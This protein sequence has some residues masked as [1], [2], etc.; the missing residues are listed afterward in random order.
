ML[1]ARRQVAVATAQALAPTAQALVATAQ[2]VV[3]SA[4]ALVASVQLPTACSVDRAVLANNLSVFSH[5]LS[6]PLPDG[7]LRVRG[8]P[9]GLWTRSRSIQ[10]RSEPLRLAPIAFRS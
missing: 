6:A 2:V 10:P 7:P 5:E 4:Q 1:T 3:A 8:C 9:L